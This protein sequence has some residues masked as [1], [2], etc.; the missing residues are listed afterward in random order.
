MEDVF[1]LPVREEFF[2]FFS[3]ELNEGFLEEDHNL[4]VNLLTGFGV[5]EPEDSRET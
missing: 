2:V 1:V 4:T 3:F 5:F